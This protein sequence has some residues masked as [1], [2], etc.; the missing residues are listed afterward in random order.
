MAFHPDSLWIGVALTAHK[1]PLSSLSLWHCWKSHWCDL[2]TH[3]SS[4][5]FASQTCSSDLICPLAESFDTMN[6]FELQNQFNPWKVAF[7][8]LQATQDDD[9]QCILTKIKV[10]ST[11]ICQKEHS[12]SIWRSSSISNSSSLF[13]SWNLDILN[14][15]MI[16][17][18]QIL[19]ILR[20]LFWWQSVWL[21]YC[22]ELVWKH[23]LVQSKTQDYANQYCHE[24]SLKW[25][26]HVEI[27]PEILQFDGSPVCA[28][29]L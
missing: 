11:S 26:C 25:H 7:T 10:F 9:H 22:Q 1:V 2:L 13:R 21:W 15:W 14:W 16:I 3:A 4:W 6:T 5:S 24:L 17:C 27:S 29:S 23:H 20:P 28:E 8:T 12:L 19:I 18:F